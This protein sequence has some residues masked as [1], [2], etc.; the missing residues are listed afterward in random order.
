MRNVT[1]ANICLVDSHLLPAKPGWRITL[2]SRHLEPLAWGSCVWGAKL[3][4]VGPWVL[5]LGCGGVLISQERMKQKRRREGMGRPGTLG[6]LL[7][8]AEAGGTV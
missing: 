4:G 5:S 3:G 2:A 6:H 1:K 8:G 7:S